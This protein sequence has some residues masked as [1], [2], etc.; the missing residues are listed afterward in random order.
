MVAVSP[1]MEVT[2]QK[3]PMNNSKMEAT[4]RGERVFTTKTCG[5]HA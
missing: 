3:L 4:I 5:K 1:T 2:P